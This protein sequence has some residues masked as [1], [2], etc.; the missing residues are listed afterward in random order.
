MPQFDQDHIEQYLRGELNENEEKAFRAQL[1]KDEKLREET[2]LLYDLHKGIKQ[3]YNQQLKEKLQQEEKLI[4]SGSN[5]WK[6][7]G[8][9][10]SFILVVSIL[11]YFL[12]NPTDYEAI[13]AENFQ[14]YPNVL[15]PSERTAT[16]LQEMEAFTYYESGNFENAIESLKSLLEKS[17]ENQEFIKLY[18]G[19][20]YLANQEAGKAAEVLNSVVDSTAPENVKL[21]ARWYLALT[22]LLQKK[23][24]DAK[25][26]LNSLANDSSSYSAKAKAILDQM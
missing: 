23:P 20:S 7:I 3:H 6:W 18:L 17:S 9:A 14:P 22:Y 26:V 16:P 13:Y 10:A 5:N 1:A 8:I 12:L 19:V 21:P 25:S 24:D 15:Y 4:T 11:S 2:A